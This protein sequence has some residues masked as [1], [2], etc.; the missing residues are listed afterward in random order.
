MPSDSDPA[1][2]ESAKRLPPYQGIAIGLVALLV[3]CLL[4]GITGSL[5]SR[6]VN[7]APSALEPTQA[8][9]QE[10]PAATLPAQPGSAP[11]EST[12]APSLA[13]T[14]LEDLTATPFDQ[15]TTL[16]ATSPMASYIIIVNVKSLNVRTGPG[17]DYPVIIT[18]PEGT[19]LIAIGRDADASWFVIQISPNQQGWLSVPLVRY[20]FDRDTLP[21]MPPPPIT[22]TTP[23]PYG[24]AILVPP[25]LAGSQ[26]LA[27]I[28]PEKR[29]VS[30]SVTILLA[31]M[32][33]FTER[34]KLSRLVK[35]TVRQA[36]VLATHHLQL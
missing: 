6:L 23:T 34:Q 4:A 5:L 31:S 18:Y 3:I 12:I 36:L 29:L 24:G 32:L 8:A 14:P 21:I 27:P 35:T 13:A 7:R 17:T 20:V 25:E 22:F 2:N 30:L 1:S 16:P 11:P 19:Q 15:A 33:A 10:V 28:R 9:P 26:P